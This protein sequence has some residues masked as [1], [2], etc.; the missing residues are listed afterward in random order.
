MLKTVEAS[1]IQI[2]DMR[3]IPRARAIQQIDRFRGFFWAR[4]MDVVIETPESTRVVP[5]PDP[6]RTV[7]MACC[8]LCA[9]ALLSAL[10]ERAVTRR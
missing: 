10:I 5:I 3:I 2:G 7:V 1:P 6:T 9:A 4:P 8:G